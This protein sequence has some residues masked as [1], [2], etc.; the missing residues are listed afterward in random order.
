MKYLVRKGF[1]VVLTAWALSLP[2]M[3]A[4]L[5][6]LTVTPQPIQLPDRLALTVQEI[7]GVAWYDVFEGEAG[8]E[9]FLQ[10]I[11]VT[12]LAFDASATAVFTVG[13]DGSLLAD[14]PYRLVVAARDVQGRD[15]AGVAV[16]TQTGSWDGT[17]RWKNSQPGNDDGLPAALVARVST[18]SLRMV[19]SKPRHEVSIQSA[20]GRMAVIAILGENTYRAQEVQPLADISAEERAVVDFLMQF[21]R[22]SYLPEKMGVVSAEVEAAHARIVYRFEFDS[23]HAD[24]TADY[25]LVSTGEGT[26]TLQMAFT[27]EGLARRAIYSDPENTSSGAFVLVKD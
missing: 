1:L 13:G 9:R 10:R 15:I 27:G 18:R 3:G 8:A 20:D 16:R 5:E 2:V 12:S 19:G 17:Y 26:I 23:Y 11:E 25:R 24:I 14:T 22:T 6:R 21:N 7:D 4:P